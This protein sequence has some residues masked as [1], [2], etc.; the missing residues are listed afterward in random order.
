[1]TFFFAGSIRGGRQQQPM[2]EFLVSELNHIGQVLNPHIADELVS[3]FGETDVT[4]K[5]IYTRELQRLAQC[6]VFIAEVTTPSLGVGY[7]IAQA[8]QLQKRV[9]CFY[10]GTDTFKLSAMI[11]GNEHVEVFA[12]STQEELQ[13]ILKTIF[14]NN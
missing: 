2:Y 8:L 7:L 4:K 12:Y 13:I 3:N 10:Q 6:D 5:Q 14:V 9:I 11:K 1:M